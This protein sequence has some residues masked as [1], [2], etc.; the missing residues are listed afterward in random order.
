MCGRARRTVQSKPGR[1]H[2]SRAGRN[3]SHRLADGDAMACANAMRMFRGHRMREQSGKGQGRVVW[4]QRPIQTNA[5][6]AS[7]HDHAEP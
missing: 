2:T 5:R 3:L 1:K 4:Q 6:F 7:S